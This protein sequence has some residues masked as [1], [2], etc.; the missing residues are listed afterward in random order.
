MYVCA[1]IYIYIY[2]YTY[3]PAIQIPRHAKARAAVFS[4]Q[5]PV[6][7]LALECPEKGEILM[8]SNYNIK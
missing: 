6:S 7:H 1:Y 8:M 5:M 4:F 2:I 3:P